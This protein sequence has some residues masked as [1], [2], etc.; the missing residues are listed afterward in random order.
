MTLYPVSL[1][2]HHIN[3][4]YGEIQDDEAAANSEVIHSIEPIPDSEVIPSSKLAQDKTN[5]SE[6]DSS[7]WENEREESI[8]NDRNDFDPT[9]TAEYIEHSDKIATLE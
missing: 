3:P 5:S 1:P 9:Q 8:K 7:E 2:D 6:V 4:N